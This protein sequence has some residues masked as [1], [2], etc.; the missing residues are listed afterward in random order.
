MNE[1][2]IE[3]TLE[4]LSQRLAEVQAQIGTIEGS[5]IAVRELI[6]TIEGI[7]AAFKQTGSLLPLTA[8]P[9]EAA[10]APTAEAAAAAAPAP[11]PASAAEANEPT[12]P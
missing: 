4:R 7:V 12:A 1:R 9:T 5:T 8:Q 11:A 2:E 3:I 10:P 6:G